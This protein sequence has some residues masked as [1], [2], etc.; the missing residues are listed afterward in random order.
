MPR[1]STLQRRR[2]L[3]E[4]IAAG[5]VVVSFGDGAAGFAGA[6]ALRTDPQVPAAPAEELRLSTPRSGGT[7]LAPT[8]LV[9]RK[10]TVSE[11]SGVGRPDAGAVLSFRPHAVALFLSDLTDAGTTGTPLLAPVYRSRHSR[12]LGRSK[13]G[14]DRSPWP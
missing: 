1:R 10:P 6:V 7:P 13:R 5:S 8:A 14:I 4:R 9:T 2:Q 12:Y 11:R 3:Q